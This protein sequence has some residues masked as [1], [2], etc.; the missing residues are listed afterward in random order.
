MTNDAERTKYASSNLPLVQIADN[1][2]MMADPG[3]SE[4]SASGL[5]LSDGKFSKHWKTGTYR[6]ICQITPENLV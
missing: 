3:S 2:A 5:A 4:S 6:V 1:H